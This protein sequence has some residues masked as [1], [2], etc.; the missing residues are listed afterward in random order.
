MVSQR[1]VFEERLLAYLTL[2]ELVSYV[3]DRR[4]MAGQLTTP[5]KR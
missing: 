2:M 4:H 1:D 3:V 5:A